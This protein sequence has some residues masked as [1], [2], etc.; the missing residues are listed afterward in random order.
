MS[1]TGETP[2]AA[3]LL[4]TKKERGA[5]PPQFDY[6]SEA[7]GDN[8]KGGLRSAGWGRVCLGDCRGNLLALSGRVKKNCSGRDAPEDP[9]AAVG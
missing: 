5:A 6:R 7:G 2:G 8:L 1:L 9:A 3:R 4:L